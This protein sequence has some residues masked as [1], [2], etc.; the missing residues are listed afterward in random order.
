[1]NRRLVI[2]ALLIFHFLNAQLN[3]QNVTTAIIGGTL[4]N[5]NG[6]P[7]VENSVILLSGEKILQAGP[8][9]AVEVPP[10]TEVI[11]AEGKWIIPG[12]IDAHIHFFQSGG[13]YTRPDAI[14]L[15]KHVSYAEEELKLIRERLPDTFARYL[16]CGITSV[17]D[18]GGPLWNFEVRAQ[19]ERTELA[20]TVAVAGPLISTLHREALVTDDPPIIKVKSAREARRLVR[21]QAEMEPDLIKIWYIADRPED[22]VPSAE[23]TYPIIEATI[24][25]SHKL[26]L[27]V[28]VHAMELETA[29]LAV[30]AGA[31]VLV[32]SVIDQEVDEDF[33]ESLKEKQVIYTPTIAVLENYDEIFSQQ[34]NFL[35]V[36]HELANPYIMGTLFDLRHLPEEDI[37]ERIRKEITEAK[38]VV[39][40]TIALKNLKLIQDAGVLV[41]AGT[42]AGNIGTLHGPSMFRELEL[43]A[44]AGLSPMEILID[45]TLNSARVMGREDKL[46]TIEAGK[47]A[48]LVIL[49]ADPLANIMNTSNIHAVVKHGRYY[50]AKEIIQPSPADIVQRQVN[51]YNAHDIE[52][53][54]ATYSPDIEIFY[55]P[56]SLFMS[57]HEAMRN[58]YGPL[59]ENTPA[60]HCEISSRIVLGRYVIDRERVTGTVD[61]EAIRA[62]A[63]YEV[64]AGLIRRV[65][66]LSE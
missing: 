45:A 62:V 24:R 6:S 63:I 66:F 59:F 39:S 56:D 65:W 47:L 58:V 32:H 46:G 23:K 19:A 13:L 5:T 37:P 48:D 54:M 51:A 20:P 40:S 38:P 25:E 1:M 10:G 18:V 33:I 60:L 11:S 52:A 42:D 61:G 41:A 28:A 17:V 44:Q 64:E 15:R 43:M 2:L 22:G 21:K 27:R 50:P 7:P 55:H 12:L 30:E 31:D 35:P 8:A 9:D 4:V 49:N 16:R 57:G 53:F 34:T 26:G 3:A 29:K 36:E 14:D